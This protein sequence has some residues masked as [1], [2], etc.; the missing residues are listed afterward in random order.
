MDEDTEEQVTKRTQALMS[1]ILEVNDLQADDL[2]SVIFTATDDVKSMFPATAGRAMGLDT[3]PLI[4][5]R[6][7]DVKGSLALCIRV[8]VHAYTS[9]SASD[10]RHV[11]L[12]G[13]T[14]LRDDL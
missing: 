1:S 12:E 13:A 4:C 6:E 10:I 11:Y 2:V 14:V 5:A 8:L 9:R 7:L 3:V